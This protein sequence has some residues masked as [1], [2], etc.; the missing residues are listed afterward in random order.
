MPSGAAELIQ[1]KIR[2]AKGKL[3]DLQ[4]S[5][6]AILAEQK[7]AATQ[8]KR[9]SNAVIWEK[10]KQRCRRWVD[11]HD[12]RTFV[13]IGGLFASLVLPFAFVAAI[14]RQPVAGIVVGLISAAV[15]FAAYYFVLCGSDETTR[16]RV[17][18]HE[19]A[20]N[21]AKQ[22][23]DRLQDSLKLVN[24]D[25]TGTLSQLS[26]WEPELARQRAQEDETR[27]KNAFDNLSKTLYEE[28]WRELRGIDFENYVARVFQ[29]LGYQVEETPT[30]GDQGVDLIV[31]AGTKRLAVQIKGYYHSVGNSA[32]QEV[33]AGMKLHQ[34]SQT[35][36]VTNSK[37]TK[38]AID[39]ASANGCQCIGEDNFEN[40][41]YGQVFP[42]A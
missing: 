33:V 41:I 5:Q 3:A 13:L 30:T 12:V 24:R 28:R 32:V 37:F 17:D 36:V 2:E 29:H 34:C 7:S 15:A 22:Q 18:H 6:D 25:I 14:L 11:E 19:L 10:S 16:L 21:Q 27:R 9:S 35:S 26:A 23:L 42:R 8:I 1:Q 38:S 40:F 20:K 39:L 31:I 4:A